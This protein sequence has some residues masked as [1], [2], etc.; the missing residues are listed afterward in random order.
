MESIFD[1]GASAMSSRHEL[2][3]D[4]VSSIRGGTYD[5]K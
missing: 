2:R 4:L 3:L 5:F 1:E